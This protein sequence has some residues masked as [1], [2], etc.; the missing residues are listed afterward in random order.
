MV[1]DPTKNQ[2]AQLYGI[3]CPGILSVV[4]V[5]N[6]YA[7]YIFVLLRSSIALYPPPSR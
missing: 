1:G 2:P 4:I 5:T 7:V 3:P 6:I